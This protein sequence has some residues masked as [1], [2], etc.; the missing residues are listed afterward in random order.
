[1]LVADMAE[2]HQ[3]VEPAL[4]RVIA[5]IGRQIDAGALVQR[6]QGLRDLHLIEQ[7]AEILRNLVE[8]QC[9]RQRLGAGWQI[10]RIVADHVIGETQID[11]RVPQPRATGGRTQRECAAHGRKATRLGQFQRNHATQRAAEWQDFARGAGNAFEHVEQ[12]VIVLD[13]AEQGPATLTI[14]G[15]RDRIALGEHDRAQRAQAW[16]TAGI[17]ENEAML[18]HDQRATGHP[19]G[20]N[21]DVVPRARGRDAGELPRGGAHVPTRPQ[22]AQDESQAQIS[23]HCILQQEPLAPRVIEERT[24]VPSRLL[25]GR[26]PWPGGQVKPATLSGTLSGDARRRDPDR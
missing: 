10:A 25:R 16:W 7:V 22:A 26:P 21:L 23:Q 20:W 3:F 8:V 1:M 18:V 17:L 13:C 6:H 9:P 2:R 14:A 12:F 24:V 15:R 4:H 5:Q 11:R 19:T